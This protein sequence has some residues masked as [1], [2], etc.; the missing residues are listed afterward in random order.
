MY[1]DM[2][3]E[4]SQAIDHSVPPQHLNDIGLVLGSEY[5]AQ[6]DRLVPGFALPFQLC[7][8]AMMSKPHHP[9]MRHVVDRVVG[10]LQDASC[11]NDTICVHD[12]NDVT[13][14]TGPYVSLCIRDAI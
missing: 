6:G 12:P 9:I 8:W 11:S 7:Q 10:R 4:C 1:V 14:I 2:E 5:D 13:N 3:T